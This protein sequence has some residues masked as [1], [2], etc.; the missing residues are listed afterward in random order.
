MPEKEGQFQTISSIDE[1]TVPTDQRRKGI[2][3]STFSIFFAV[4]AVL[5]AVALFL[6]DQL[7]N[8]GYRQIQTASDRYFQAESIANNLSAVSDDLT[9][10]VRCHVVTGDRQYM[11]AFLTEV[12][13]TRRRDQTVDAMEEML[14]QKD[15][16]AYRN[17]VQ[18]QALSD[19]LVKTELL[20]M[21]LVLEAEHADP[22]EIPEPLQQLENYDAELQAL[23]EEEKQ[24]KAVELVFG[25]EYQD[26]KQEI[27]ASTGLSQQALR[28]D[29]ASGMEAAGARLRHLLLLQTVLTVIML[30]VVLI[31]VVFVLVQVRRPLMQMVQLMKEK[32]TIPPDGAEELRFVTRTYNRMVEETRK[33]TE[34]LTYEAMHDGL[35]G[36]LNRNAYEIFYRDTD[37]DHAALLIIDVDKF[38]GINDTYGHDGGDRV[39]KRVAEVLRHSFRSVDMIY[40]FGG[41]EFVVIMTRANSSMRDLLLEKINQANQ[42]LLQGK[43]N[44][45]PA[46]LSVGV[47]FCDRENPQGDLLK[48]AD[49]ALYRVK[50]AGRCGCAIY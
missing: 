40:R 36:L 12:Y 47:A 1:P 25:Q 45:P 41:D 21:R 27:Q 22:A 24:A 42:L 23:S 28:E 32:K 35:T 48:D 16:E 30:A 18:A 49:T 39:L 5:A 19:E 34:Q 2:R 31:I 10:A 14:G 37:L 33:T 26:R 43:D 44:I 3:L 38:K 15:S 4:I 50:E 20:A 7:V 9:E 11:E 6:A 8:D 17:L 46:S 29:T 13:E